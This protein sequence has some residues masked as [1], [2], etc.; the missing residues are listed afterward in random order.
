MR[1]R[2]QERCWSPLASSSSCHR[3]L[4]G[5]SGWG[6]PWRI[7]YL[8]LPPIADGPSS[9]RT[10]FLE[11]LT[12]LGY[13]D[14]RSIAIEYRSAA[15]NYELLPDLAQELVDSK[16]DVIVALGP[17]AVQAARDATKSIPVVFL[18]NDDPVSLGL[19]AAIRHPGGNLTGV[20]A[21]GSPDLTGKRLELLTAAVPRARRIAVLWNPKNPASSLQW[22]QMQVAARKLGVALQSLAVSRADDFLRAFAT[23]SKQRPDALVTVQDT[24]THS[25]RQI[26][27]EFSIQHRLPA[28]M[29]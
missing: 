29:A 4:P 28:A 22:K 13:V 15:W 6:K 3:A 21:L 17:P 18:I 24:L 16:V 9:E 26:I 23:M 27:A 7:G 2:S 25:Y 20:T 5:P 1:G 11:G 12:K 14:G 19:V 10:A 8:L